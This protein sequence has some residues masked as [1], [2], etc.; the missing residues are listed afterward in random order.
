MRDLAR[1]IEKDDDALVVG[2]GDLIEAIGYSDFRFDPAEVSDWVEPQHLNNLFYIEAAYFAKLFAKTSGKWAMCIPGNHE[3]TVVRRYHFDPTARIAEWMGCA[4][5]GQGDEAGWL[6]L[7]MR[8]GDGKVRNR[9]RIYCQHGWGGGELRGGDALKLERL[10]YRKDAHAVVM[11]HVHRPHA[12]P[13]TKE[14]ITLRGWEEAQE[15]WGVISYPMV[16]KHGYIA[17]RGG[18]A[19]PM[20]YAVLTIQRMKVGPPKMGVELKSL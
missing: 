7:K 9:V 12:F 6:M 3:S 10:C 11:A 18:N 20:G 14:A 2:L 19:P 15:T 16:E 13:V 8:E 17:R 1:I 5:Q 4:Y